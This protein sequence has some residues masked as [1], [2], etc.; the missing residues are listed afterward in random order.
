MRKMIKHVVMWK[1]KADVTEDD[2]QEMKRQLEALMGVVPSLLKI[3]VGLDIAGKPASMDMV[4][5]TEFQSLEDLQAYAVHPA[6]QKVVA[7]VKPLVAERAVVD[8]EV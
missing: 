6:H 8:Y 2:Q 1:F 5:C 4:L 7:F 3:E